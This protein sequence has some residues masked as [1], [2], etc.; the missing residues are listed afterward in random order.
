MTPRL[1]RLN[2]DYERLKN[3]FF[4]WSLIQIKEAAG[5]PPEKYQFIYYLKGL[6]V[7]SGGQI[8]EREQHVLEVSLSLGY[9]RRA[10]HCKMISP[11]FHPNFDDSSV[12]IGDYWAASEGLED[13]VIRI[14]R[15]LTYQD[16]NV[17]S[18][19]NGLAAKWAAENVALLPVD[20][21][22]VA[23]PLQSDDHIQVEPP[24]IV[25]LPPIIDSLPPKPTVTPQE[26]SDPWKDKVVIDI[27][28]TGLFLENSQ[29][30]I[31]PE[32][33]LKEGIIISISTGLVLEELKLVC[34]YCKQSM[35]LEVAI[36]DQPFKC[37]NCGNNHQ[38]LKHDT[39]HKSKSYAVNDNTSLVWIP[40]GIYMMGSPNSYQD[41]YN[42]ESPQTQVTI[43]YGY[44][45]SKYET[46]Q[47][48]YVAV[49]KVNPAHFKGDIKRPVE[50]VNWYDA[51]IYCEILTSLERSSG[52][53]PAGYEFRLPTEAEWEYAC[54]AGT[55]EPFSHGHDSKYTVL[56]R[57][58]WFS[59][60][61]EIETH[62]VGQKQPNPWGL[63][64]MHGNIWEWCLDRY[65][66]YSGGCVIDPIGPNTGNGRVVRGGGW[67]SIGKECRVSARFKYC[68]DDSFNNV[69]FRVV[70]APCQ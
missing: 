24:I 10:P 68:P 22:E 5:S 55:T 1:K 51:S 45:M 2:Q 62:A 31:S 37:P 49:M 17:K 69:G 26:E 64:D 19:L 8:L 32:T 34:I 14:G 63:Y 18:P 36:F 43:S 52:K 6:Y 25:Q 29:P 44:W 41:S 15:M 23:P 27:E 30:L 66:N 48:E 59:I 16:Y 7:G 13:L 11:V 60:N 54:R 57:Y 9:P 50:K 56:D 38:V 67:D 4:N 61:S 70:L 21:R 65:G 39:Q 58:A 42:D 46:T 20:T 35:L 40:D 33:T 28:G 3:R 53:L 12:C 47:E